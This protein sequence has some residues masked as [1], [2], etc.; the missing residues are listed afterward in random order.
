MYVNEVELSLT[1]GMCFLAQ[2]VEAYR[3]FQLDNAWFI[4]IPICLIIGIAVV[5]CCVPASRVFP[6]DMIML[7]MFV[8]S[9]GYI[10][11]MACSALVDDGDGPVVPIAVG[12]TM[13][14]TITITI[15]A[16]LCKG[17][18]V[19]WIGIVLVAAAAALVIGI[20]AIFVDLPALIYV[21]C[22]LI[23]LILS[24]YL[25]F[26]TKMIIGG[27][28]PEFPIDNYILASLFLYLYIM[29]IFMYILMILGARK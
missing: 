3:E 20:T 25:V 12:A 8:L 9:F 1:F 16:F 27:D 19:A 18:F 24:I 17:N 2:Y 29:R 22:S 14:I 10:V 7:L 6:L 13:A 23:I 4:A 15:Y 28:F 11:S 21:Y 26:I 5:T